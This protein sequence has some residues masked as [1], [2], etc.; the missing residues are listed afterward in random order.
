MRFVEDE[1]SELIELPVGQKVR[2]AA[3]GDGVKYTAE[4]FIDSS[5]VKAW[6]HA[7]L[8]I[9]EM[10]KVPIDVS[11]AMYFGSVDNRYIINR[12]Q[13]I[14]TVPYEITINLTL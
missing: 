9:D 11:N 14:Q 5:T 3:I 2:I 4:V 12:W 1:W 13:P 7:N 8:R 10:A 6:F